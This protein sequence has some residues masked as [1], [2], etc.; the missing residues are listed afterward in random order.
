[1]TRQKS[2]DEAALVQKAMALFWEQGYEATSVRELANHLGISLSSLYNTFGGKHELYLLAL[3]AHR[4]EEHKQLAAVLA[5]AQ[6]ARAA[7]ATLFTDLA[8]ELLAD[9]AH[10]GS[11]TMN[12]AIELGGRDPAV[13][14]QLREHFS[15]ITTL[16]ADFLAAAQRRG[17]LAPGP[18]PAS[19]AT[20]FALNIY[21]LATLVRINPSPEAIERFIAVAL[22]ALPPGQNP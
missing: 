13:I 22:A 14:A 20:F 3:A 8:Q 12:A 9:E 5:H 10:R 18:D 1:M 6:P 11:F 7:L 17:E 15:V 4:Q 16:L 2:F 19:L 21:S